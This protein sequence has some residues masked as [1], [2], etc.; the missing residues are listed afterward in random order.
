MREISSFVSGN[1]VAT[2]LLLS[3]AVLGVSFALFNL[4]D[5][6]AAGP[7]QVQCVALEG[8]MEGDGCNPSGGAGQN[9]QG[10][11]APGYTCTGPAVGLCGASCVPATP[12]PPP[13]PPPGSIGE[14]PQ[15]P[16]PPPPVGFC[17]EPPPYPPIPDCAGPTCPLCVPEQPDQVVGTFNATNP[18]TLTINVIST[19]QFYCSDLYNYVVSTQPLPTTWAGI[20]PYYQELQYTGPGVIHQWVT[21]NISWTSPSLG[22]YQNQ[23]IY[24]GVREWNSCQNISGPFR[25]GG[26]VVVPPPPPPPPVGTP[27]CG[28]AW[29]ATNEGSNMGAGWVSFNRRDCDAD[30]DG[31]SDGTPVGCPAAG[32][33]IPDYGVSLVDAGGGIQ[34]LVGYAWSNNLGWLKFGGLS[35][36]PTTGGNSQQQASILGGNQIHG[37]A[38]FCEGSADGNCGQTARTDGWDGW[39]SLRGAAPNYGVSYSTANQKFSGNSWGGPVVGWLNWDPGTGDGVRLCTTQTLTATLLAEPSS[40]PVPL[41]V[42]LTAIPGG[43]ASLDQAQLAQVVGGGSYEYRFKCKSTDPNWSPWQPTN[44]YECLYTTVGDFIAQGEIRLNTLTAMGQAPVSTYEE[45]TGPLGVQC[46]ASSPALVNKPVTWTITLN[47]EVPAPPYTYTLAFDNEPAVTLNP[48]SE[49]VITYTKTYST[50]GRKTLHV[51]VEDSSG[52]PP[53]MDDCDAE[54][55]VRVQPT[56]KEI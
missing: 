45:T 32:T 23:N 51:D 22:S 1:K 27:V 47:P 3:V 40:G 44:T 4:S 41:P 16:P 11:C 50:L 13:P 17:P 46:S 33:T 34:N 14:D 42:T 12:P 43:S 48:T 37:W 55:N 29:A 35:G 20:A 18:V 25:Q 5:L 26:P 49:V 53:V 30:D 21:S 31:Q 2:A 7:Q 56:I 36:M 52:P 6:S 10:S 15:P 39:V 38:R 19:P 24:Y 8:G 54:A 28:W 9:A